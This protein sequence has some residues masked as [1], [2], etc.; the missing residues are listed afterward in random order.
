MARSSSTSCTAVALVAAVIGLAVVSCVY[1]PDRRCGPAMT[2]VAAINACVCEGNAIAVPG[3]CQVCAADEVAAGDA[4]ACAAGQA[5]GA[6]GACMTVA[7]PGDPCDTASSPCS[8]PKYSY[9]AVRGTGTA[10][11]CAEPCTSSAG[12]DPASSP[13]PSGRLA[14]DRRGR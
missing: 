13:W 10:G 3:G 14:S 2:F 6:D 11:I 1:D 7:G 12:C 4:C 9:C 8:D 5:R